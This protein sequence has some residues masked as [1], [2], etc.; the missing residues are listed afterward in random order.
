MLSSAEVKSVELLNIKPKYRKYDEYRSWNE[1]G[2]NYFKK[3][4]HIFGL[5][6]YTQVTVTIVL[7]QG[8]LKAIGE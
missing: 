1:P 5:F 3:Y 6:T 7:W 2:K 8:T 4:F